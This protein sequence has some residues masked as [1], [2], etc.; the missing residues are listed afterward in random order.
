VK[1]FLEELEQKKLE[2]TE[3]AAKQAEPEIDP[4]N[5]AEELV[6]LQH[7]L[8]KTIEDEKLQGVINPKMEIEMAAR[9]QEVLS[10][11]L[12]SQLQSYVNKPTPPNQE[13]NKGSLVYELYYK[14]EY[15]KQGQNTK[16]ADLDRRLT[17]LEQLIGPAQTSIDL[18]STVEG[19]REKLTLLSSPKQL[20]VLQR[21][22]NA[23]SQDFDKLVEKKPKLEDS[24]E[25]PQ[26]VKV[27]EIFEMMNRWDVTSQQ[28]PIIVSRLQA[29]KSL[30]EESSSFQLGI[31]QLESQQEEIK[32]LLKFNGE[33]MGQVDS[34]FKQ[35]LGIVQSNVQALE[36]RITELSKK[37]EEFGLETF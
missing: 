7:L 4:G 6:Q 35:N 15:V 21:T 12:L 26:D 17:E 11:K 14:P 31:Q 20:E 5:I 36:Q 30:H 10:K 8:Q 29:L 32:K 34:N 3:E 2:K 18:L 13:N 28:L 23:I 16:L 22:I 1:S 9:T 27:N 25:K 33:L 24:N 19:L 37:L